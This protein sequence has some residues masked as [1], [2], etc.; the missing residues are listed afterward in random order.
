MV[1]KAPSAGAGERVRNPHRGGGPKA[2]TTDPADSAQLIADLQG[3]LAAC[4][5]ERDAGLAREAALAEV[6]QTT[7]SSPGDLTP[8]FDAILAKAHALCGVEHGALVTYDGEYFRLAAHRGMPQFWVKQF[9]QPY[10]GS[11]LHERLLRGERYVQVADARA[12]AETL[13][14]RLTIRAGTRTILMVPLRKEGALLGF[15]TA[16]L[17]QV[18]L[19]SEKEIALLEAFAAQAVIAMENARLLGELQARTA[20][21][22]ERNSA[23]AERIDHQAATIDVL[24]EMSASPADAQPVFDLICDQ[25]RALTGVP[26]VSLFEYDGTLAHIR[27]SSRPSDTA[28]PMA[29]A[30]YAA[31]WPRVPDRGSLSCRAILDGIIVHVR[32]MDAEPGV[33]AEVRALGH[34]TQVSIPLMRDG[35]ATG[36]ITTA[37]PQVDAVSDTQIELLKTFA[38]QAVI[39]IQS[40]ETWRELQARTR[41]LEESLEYQT[42]TSDVLKVISRS[43]ADVQPVLDT[44]AETAARLCANDT[45]TILIRAGDVYR[46]VANCGVEPEYWAILSQRTMIPNRDTIAG[47]AALEGRVVHVEDIRADPDYAFP[48]NVASGRRTI[49]G[50]PLL[51]DNEPIGVISLARNRVEP[52]TERQIEL[53]RTF[54]DQAVIAIENARL[55]TELQA[56]TRDL[57]ESLEY[58]TATSDVL[59]VISRSAADVQPV[60]DTVVETAARLCGADSGSIL[61]REG[62]A[63]RYV[64]STYMAAEPGFWA[65][66]LQR[67]IVPGRNSVAGR[68]VLEGRVVHVE[69]VCADPDYALP[70][71][72]ATGRRTH[73]GVPLLRDG[74]PIGVIALSR[75]RV[76]LFTERQIELVRT[77]ADQAVIAIENARL[78]GELQTRTAELA[79]RNSAF[80][81]RI[82]YQAATIDV[83]KEMSASPADAQPVFDLVCHQARALLGVQSVGLFEYDGTLVHIR[84]STSRGAPYSDPTARAVYD[85]GWPRVPDR[86]SLSCRAILDGAIVHVRDMDAEPGVSEEVRALGNKTQVSIP[87][88][89]DGRAIGAITTSSPRVDGISDTQIELLKTFAEQAVI[90]IQSAETWRELQARTRDLEESLEYQTATSDLL[91]VI[92]RSTFD[93]QPVLDTLVETG[94][95]LCDSDNAALSIRE[96]DVFRYVA[97]RSLDPAFDTFLR[98]RTFAPGRETLAGRVALAGEVVHI[99]DITTDPDWRLPESATLAKHRTALGVPLLRDGSVVGTLSLART[100]VE[101]FTER[102]IELVRTFADQAVIAMENARLFGELQARTRDLEESLE[103]QT[104]TSDVLNVISRS[105]ADVQ[106]VLDTLVDTAARLCGADTAAMLIREGEVY[107]YMAS[108]TRAAEPEFWALRRQQRFIPGRESIAGR[109]ALEGRVVHI[110]DI[111]AD[112]DYVQPET[113]ATGRR[114]QLG[115]PLLR[116]GAPIGIIVLSRKRMEPFTERQIELVRTFAD[117]AVIAMENAR[118]LGELQARTRDLEESL[119]YQTATSDVLKVIS[120]ST[121]DIQPVLDTVIE[122]AAR[123]CSADVGTIAIREGEVY[124]YVAMLTS[125]TDPELWAVLRQRA[126]V[127]GRDTIA[128]RVALEGRVVHVED[129]AA[130]PDYAFPEN[131]RAGRRT[132]LGV[133]LLR[134]GAVL[135]TI[136]LGRHR[137]EPF[138]ERQIEL[139][140]T[141]A[142]QAVIAMENARLLGELQA[143]TRDLEESLEYQTATSDV[144]NVISR[145]TADVQPVLDTV[146]ET[147]ARLCGADVAN[148]AIREGEVYRIVAANQAAAADAEYW[149]ALRQRTIVPSRETVTGRVALEGRV[150]HV[151]D[152]HADPDYAWPGVVASKYRTGLGVPLLREGAVIGTINLGRERVQPYTERQIELVRT[153]ADQA[154]IAMENARLLG[155]LQARTR[156]LEESLEYQTATSDVLNVISRSTADVQPV[157]DTVAETAARLCGADT[158]LISIR[159]GEVYRYVA[160][161]QA[162]VADAEYWAALRE[163]AIVPGRD[164]VAGRVALE[165]RVVHVPDILA[166]PDYTWPGVVASRFRT[167]LGVPL[168]REGTV[169]GTI[170]LARTRVEPFTERQ[171]ELVRTFADQAVIAIENAR[172]L[173]ELQARTRDLEES[174]EYQTATSEVL[175]VI[176]RSTA[177]VQPVLDTVVETAVRLCGADNGTIFIREGDVYRAVANN[178]VSATDTEFWAIQRQQRFAP[179]RGS[180]A[181][182]V[183]LES[184]VVH[185]EDLAADPDYA[186]PEA[187]AAGNRTVLGVPLLR[188]GAVLGTINLARKRV[189]PYTER[190]IELVRTFADQAVIAMENARLLSELQSRTDELTRSVGELQALEEVLR[191]VN[192]SLDLDTVLATIISR[193]AQL[194]QADEGTIYEF[195]E[196]EEVFVPKSAFGMSAERVAGLRERRVRLGETH[197]GRAAVERAPVYVDDVQQDP[198]LSGPDRG[199]LLQ[200]IHAVLAVPLLREDKVVGGLVIRRRTAGGFAPTIP[201]LLQTFA[202]QAVLAIEHARLFQEL[203]ARGEEAR[204]ARDEAEEASRTKSSFLANMSH[205]LRTPLNAIIGLTELLCDNAGRFGTE[206]ALEPL[207]RVLRAGRHLLSLINDILDLSKI[208]A[209]KMDLTLESVAIGP[210]VEEVVGTARPLAEQNKNALELDCPAGIGSVHA[211]NMRLRQILLNLL[212]NACKF[213]KGG[214]VRLRIARAEEAGQRWVDFAVSDTGIGMTEEQLGRLF[215]EF[216]QA[217]ASTTRQFGGTGLGLA[218]SRRLCRL[219]GGDITVTSA[220]GEGSTFT[221]RLPTEAAAPL[222]VAERSLAAT[223]PAATSP[224]ASQERPG[225]ILVID[226]D[227]TARELIA[228]YLTGEGFAV[229]TAAGGVEGIKKL[230]ELRPAAVTLDIMMPEIDGWT[231]LAALKGDPALAD[232]PVVIVTIVDE[233][234]RGIALGAAGYLTKPID[235][236]RLIEIVSRLRV[237][238]APGRVLVV[239]DDEDQRQLLRGI[240]GARGWS[241]REAANGRLALDAIVAELPDLILLD[242]MMPEMDGFEL[243]A[244]LQANAAWR[245]IPVVVV[246]ALDLTDEDRRRLN[247]GVEQILS[248]HAFPPAELMARVGALLGE[249][250]KAQK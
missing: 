113:V 148:I 214:T 10:R 188:E 163:R 204:R 92:S 146:I 50:V 124:R 107:R 223:G 29:R 53:V 185:V 202:D 182:R 104:A 20:E 240:L 106:P 209:G 103:Y 133:P 76:Q 177:D 36:A 117:Q 154:V 145:S 141:F 239:E 216:T 108:S 55:L 31:G 235:R 97:T 238:G 3:Q 161:N 32:D 142:D 74:E 126:V 172:L 11:S 121:A 244:A 176:S 79:E 164:S 38:E 179:G 30:A 156:D 222:T 249:T 15:I 195:D 87:L 155:E 99:P 248:K 208:E 184:R 18:R 197:L 250:R 193:A 233:Q 86:G 66:Q 58:Q 13:Q 140:R 181:A 167:G 115:A 34:K 5:A 118:L 41:D 6:L 19:F 4:R 23:F 112:P 196:T 45:A 129:L 65:N 48:E 61:T 73:L 7:N 206:K 102:Q 47:R 46:W 12:A 44:I 183:A 59:K 134:E 147:A 125:A 39:A 213:T 70:E 62:E 128:G 64:S 63:Y 37:S 241:V 120:H 49:L 200:G 220:P 230:R 138:T 1:K 242:L 232:I 157:L 229:E 136:N 35:R 93:L 98:A 153:F 130:D 96:G 17:R 28:D 100:R 60:L 207:R 72:V 57:E 166:D 24:K 111:L 84:A 139:V 150:V 158:G 231:V 68:A 218:I 82:D 169:L 217:D 132:S 170:G 75:K 201:A 174:L 33:S 119:E 26:N 137:V 187:V 109:V 225:T 226:D 91:K 192:S 159:E 81:E 22:A 71:T 90:A 234:R 180:I 221:V 14:S 189:E 247:G 85:A 27:A 205:E 186:V 16:N 95:R 219:M 168:L 246:T 94:Q 135:G 152:I 243:V 123:L 245:A 67:T 194:S 162:T 175:N 51:R 191:A 54:A 149:A 56:R 171:I 173:S 78:L 69:D 151:A 215:Q 198:T 116:D 40:A 101:P 77:F 21:L 2:T 114:T 190:Q 211:D 110:A 52:F 212:S 131:V 143:R 25:A 42:A 224:A 144:L 8:V 89:R 228:T 237:A 127:P 203:A 227:A 80:A 9:R 210:V 105:T 88:M 122:T 43:T 236:E 165:G 199:G 178:Y 83:L 160:G